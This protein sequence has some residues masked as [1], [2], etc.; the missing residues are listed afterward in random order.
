MH[1]VRK[2]FRGCGISVPL[3]KWIMQAPET[4]R[5]SA[6][7]AHNATFHAISQRESDACGL[8]PCGMLLNL[9]RSQGFV[10]SHANIGEK[11]SYLVATKP[12]DRSEVTI[13]PPAEHRGFM[14]DYYRSVDVPVRF[15]AE[16]EVP[17]ESELEAM[18]DEN[19]HTLTLL[20]NVCG[21]DLETRAAALLERYRDLPFQTVTACLDLT[22]PAAPWGY[23]VL[24]GLGF[25]FSGLQ[26]FCRGRQ[27]LWLHHPLAVT[28]PFDK[29]YVAPTHEGVF[30]YVRKNF[31][32]GGKSV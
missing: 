7:G 31:E 6:L 3:V 23:R 5:F 9:Y 15:Q 17:S 13:C 11:L 19:H 27:Y 10:H 30:R 32:A 29:M 26:P 12:L 14:E 25:R 8:R 2:A 28:L 1:V 4:A 22:H 24:T 16:G 18:Q 20:L 21:Q